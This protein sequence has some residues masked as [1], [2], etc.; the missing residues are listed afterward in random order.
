MRKL[1]NT[2]RNAILEG[3][4]LKPNVVK[5]LLGVLIH[6]RTVAH[7]DGGEERARYLRPLLDVIVQKQCDWN[8]SECARCHEALLKQYAPQERLELLLAV[9]GY[10]HGYS[11]LQ[12]ASE[13]R[14]K[15][16][17]A[18]L[19]DGY[20][21]DEKTW[22]KREEMALSDMASKM[23]ADCNSDPAKLM[24]VVLNALNPQELKALGL[25]EVSVT[26]TN[27]S[28]QSKADISNLKRAGKIFNIN[29]TDDLFVGGTRALKALQDGFKDGYSAQIIGAEKIRGKSRLALEYARL[30]ADD[31]Q[32]ICWINAWNEECIQ[33]SILNFFDI[34][35]VTVHLLTSEQIKETFVDFF[36][37]NSD[38]LIIFDNVNMIASVQKEMLESYIPVTPSNG[39]IIIT[40]SMSKGL[41]GYK[42][43]CLDNFVDP[44]DGILFLEKALAPASLDEAGAQIASSCGK[45]LYPL[46]LFT[47]Y[48]RETEQMDTETYLRLLSNCG[49]RFEDPNSEPFL[50]AAF[51]TLMHNVQIKKRY[52]KSSVLYKALEQMLIACPIF[53]Y[54]NVDLQFFNSEFPI[55]PEPLASV[56]ADAEMR[57]Q[58]ISK[59]KDFGICEIDDDVLLLN[60]WICALSTSYFDKLLSDDLCLKLL[61]AMNAAICNI[62]K[63]NSDEAILIRAKPY[64]DRICPLAS[65]VVSI[66]ELKDK[67]PAAWNLSYCRDWLPSTE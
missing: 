35:G 10:A 27:S 66:F 53:M 46:R 65:Q 6:V 30:H 17:K 12:K 18:H 61:D 57:R 21:I 15:F 9:S 3:A 28:D 59:L 2:Y 50:F 26:A 1:E 67:Y 14:R 34:A 55:L 54:C 44:D 8:N 60:D 7:K 24:G 31:Y 48:M 25:W 4:N 47:A 11:G 45:D 23:E 62:Q 19:K 36:K 39:H 33:S 5:S 49:C 32:I 29:Q 13:R 38:W 63:E 43:H 41:K 16:A 58:L 37:I 51:D 42:F 20:E 64:A 22:T 52:S 56:C 40:T